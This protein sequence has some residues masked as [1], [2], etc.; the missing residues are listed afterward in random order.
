[1]IVKF[2]QTVSACGNVWRSEYDGMQL[3]FSDDKLQVFDPDS[4][5]GETEVLQVKDNDLSCYGG[6][7]V[8][9][10]WTEDD[11]ANVIAGIMLIGGEA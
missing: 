10:H 5:N 6:E 1:M 2:T 8:T 11:W 4:Q 3:E 7:N 9:D